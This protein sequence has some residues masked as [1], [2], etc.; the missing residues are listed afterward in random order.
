VLA[1]ARERG[2]VPVFFTTMAY[3]ADGLDAVMWGHKVPAPLDLCVD[4]EPAVQIGIAPA[5][6]DLVFNKKFASAFFGTP[7]APLLASRGIDTVILTGCSM[8]GYVGATA[9][10][11]VSYEL[12]VDRSAGMRC[13]SRASAHHANL[14]DI[15]A[16]YDD[17]VSVAEVLEYLRKGSVGEAAE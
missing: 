5:E 8:S 2:D 4:D 6:N 10:D 1:A 16:K 13:S 15:Q 12:S 17:V 3:D 11:A 9:V 7:L 14:F